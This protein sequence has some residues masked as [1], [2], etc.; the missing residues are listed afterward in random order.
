MKCHS[1]PAHPRHFAFL[2]V[3]LSCLALPASAGSWIDFVSVNSSGILGND[4]SGATSISADGRYVAFGSNAF[5][6]IPG[7]V[8]YYPEVYLRDTVAGTTIRINVDTTGGEPVAGASYNPAVSGDG[9]Y[10]AFDS[11]SSSLVTGDTNATYDVFVR[12]TVSNTTT[13]VSVDSAGIQANNTSTFPAISADGRYVAFVSIATNLVPGGTSGDA[14]IYVHDRDTGATSLVSVDS[15]GTEG[16]DGSGP[17]DISGDGRYVAF[18]SRATNLVPGGTNQTTWQ[19]IFVH[20]RDAGTTSLV[21]ADSAGNDADTG[22]GDPTI[23]HDGRYIAFTS[24]ATNLVTG[25]TN[26]TYD[27]FV[28]DTV[29]NT[30]TRVSVDSAGN[31]G[32][33]TSYRTAISGDGRYVAF[34]SF[35]PNLVVNDGN[36]FRDIFLHDRNTGVTSRVSVDEAGGE[37][38]SH[39]NYPLVSADGRYVAFTTF[40]NNLVAGD[41]NARTD[42]FIK[43]IP[44]VE[45]TSVVP[46]SL[47]R[48]QTTSVTI[49]GTYFLPGAVPELPNASTSNVVISNEST[50]TTDFTVPSNA[51]TGKQDVSVNLPGTGPGLLTGSVATCVDCVTVPAGC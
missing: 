46:D 1:H 6:L 2:I 21:S 31:Q 33:S 8:Y 39:S 42:A 51:P 28:R 13:R 9:R 12:D 16:N 5:N 45:V 7:D 23:S 37:A 24:Y 27:V 3:S 29:S 49:S 50:M 11:G 10:V 34:N 41:S 19:H 36:G 38:N 26:A 22:S 15:G 43:A 25:D 4:D 17:A 30:T 40:A 32:T 14:H 47:P 44:Q 20:D 35:S 18:E 48:G